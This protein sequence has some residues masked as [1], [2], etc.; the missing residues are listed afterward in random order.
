MSESGQNKSNMDV[1][2]IICDV[3]NKTFKSKSYLKIHKRTHSGKK[4]Y[5]CEKGDLTRHMLVHNGKK[6][7][8]CF[9]CLK[10][11]QRKEHL[12]QRM[13]SHTK[14]KKF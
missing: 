7:F 3:C 11:F 12:K 5:K 14:E 1:K 2:S 13:V 10:E 6:D 8:Q 4:P 9:V